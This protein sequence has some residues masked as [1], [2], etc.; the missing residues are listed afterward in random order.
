MLTVLNPQSKDSV[1]PRQ[2]L[3]P[4]FRVHGPH[5]GPSSRLKRDRAYLYPEVKSLNPEPGPA[6]TNPDGTCIRPT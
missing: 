1:G 3:G 2:G 4:R 6:S 5:L